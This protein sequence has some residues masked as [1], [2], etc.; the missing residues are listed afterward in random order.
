V[1]F[2][3]ELPDVVTGF[4]E[5]DALVRGGRPEMLRLT[6]LLLARAVRLTVT[7]PFDPRFIVSDGCDNEI[8]KSAC[9]FSVTV[10]ECVAK[11]VV[12]VP[13]MVSV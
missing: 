2:N 3:V 4:D 1:I 12:S 7:V 5:N 6:E 9:T 11:V 13:V 8:E 10:A